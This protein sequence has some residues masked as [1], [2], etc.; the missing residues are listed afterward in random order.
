MVF[1][2]VIK[3]VISGI[4]FVFD[5]NFYLKPNRDLKDG[6]LC[7]RLEFLIE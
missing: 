7:I 5:F 3:C 4:D 6:M 1:E 2:R